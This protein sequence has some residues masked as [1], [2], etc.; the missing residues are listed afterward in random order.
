[1]RRADPKKRLSPLARMS[2][3]AALKGVVAGV[4]LGVASFEHMFDT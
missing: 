1:M 2:L 4:A 3:T